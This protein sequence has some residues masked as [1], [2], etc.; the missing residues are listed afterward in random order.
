MEKYQPLFLA[1]VERFDV[2]EREEALDL[3]RMLLIEAIEEYDENK[4]SF[5][6]FLK[7]KLHYYFLDLAKIERPDSLNEKDGQGE[8][9]IHFIKDDFDFEKDLIKKEDT[10]RLIELCKDLDE[11]ERE[12]L[13]LKYDQGLTHKEIGQRLG[14]A[15]K[16]IRNTHSR[17]IRTLR[18]G[19]KKS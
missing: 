6:G 17:T 19:M 5:G 7:Y 4:A 15:P 9:K 3:C 13:F 18:K 14:L 16:T 1:T 8:E 10:K 2:F 12:I 11:R